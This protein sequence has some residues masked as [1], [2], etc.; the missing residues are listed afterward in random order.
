MHPILICMALG[1]LLGAGLAIATEQVPAQ[2]V[3]S[4]L[5]KYQ[6][7]LRA[8]DADGDGR[9]SKTEA[10]RARMHRIVESFDQLDGNRDGLLTPAEIRML[11]RSRISS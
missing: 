8:A 7:Q 5:S 3:P 10:A 9:L 2:P 1:T 4:Y 6:D 11:L